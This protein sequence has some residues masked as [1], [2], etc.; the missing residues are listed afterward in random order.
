MLTTLAT[1]APGA[2]G[3]ALDE[4]LVAAAIVG[5]VMLAFGWV[6]LRERQGRPTVVGRLAD[7]VARVDGL[8]RWCGLPIYLAVL[9]LLTAAFGVW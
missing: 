3:A 9:S 2:G 1:E 4:V 6:T 5:S 7:R 8:P